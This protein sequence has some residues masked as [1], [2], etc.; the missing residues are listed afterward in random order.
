MTVSD[1][2]QKSINPNNLQN[3]LKRQGDFLLNELIDL[4]QKLGEDYV[5]IP[6][7]TLRRQRND[8]SKILNEVKQRVGKLDCEVTV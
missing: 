6:A 5:G 1:Y 2:L 8:M 3:V 4:R 7:D